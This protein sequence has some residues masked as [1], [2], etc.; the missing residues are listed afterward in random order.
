[1]AIGLGF[2]MSPEFI[3][4]LLH[5]PSNYKVCSYRIL[6]V[7]Y[8]IHFHILAREAEP[9]S[10][11]ARQSRQ[12][13]SSNAVRNFQIDVSSNWFPPFQYASNISRPHIKNASTPK[14][15]CYVNVICV[16]HMTPQA[17]WTRF[18]AIP[19]STTTATLLCKTRAARAN[20]HQACGYD[21][22][23]GPRELVGEAT[24]SSDV[25][26]DSLSHCVLTERFGVGIP[27]AFYVIERILALGTREGWRG[28]PPL[29]PKWEAARMEIRKRNQG[30][31]D[32]PGVSPKRS[33][34]AWCCQSN[35]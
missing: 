28:L 30:W 5:I 18:D 29:I 26:W 10:P 19:V 3:A 23:V 6:T 8:S 12:F 9:D 15:L 16:L 24:Q 20:C 7:R 35:R 1:M 4:A 22:C 33:S 17:S 32:D 21:I 11:T 34:S 13:E 27:A 2:L 31:L 14:I 25:A